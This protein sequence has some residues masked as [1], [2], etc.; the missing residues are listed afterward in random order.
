MEKNL[1]RVAI[2]AVDSLLRDL[3]TATTPEV[4]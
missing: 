3:Q 2:L 4:W 1:N